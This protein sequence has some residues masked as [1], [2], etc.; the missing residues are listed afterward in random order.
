[1]KAASLKNFIRVQEQYGKMMSVPFWPGV[2]YPLIGT[3]QL[4]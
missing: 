3:E 2:Q 1:V 4:I